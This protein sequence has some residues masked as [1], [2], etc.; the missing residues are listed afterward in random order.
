MKKTTGR[1]N[2]FERHYLAVNAD[3]TI[4]LDED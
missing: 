3:P 2:E 1:L 4:R